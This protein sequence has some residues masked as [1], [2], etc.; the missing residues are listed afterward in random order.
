VQLLMPVAR[1][2]HGQSCGRKLRR[3]QP[4]GD[5]SVCQIEVQ[6]KPSVTATRDRPAAVERLGRAIVAD[7]KRPHQSGHDAKALSLGQIRQI[8]EHG[9]ART[10]HREMRFH[11]TLRYH[12]I[13]LRSYSPAGVPGGNDPSGIRERRLCFLNLRKTRDDGMTDEAS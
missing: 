3:A 7:E 5:A 12:G 4:F 10:F 6:P 13:R 8:E 11:G 1:Q 9:R 2:H